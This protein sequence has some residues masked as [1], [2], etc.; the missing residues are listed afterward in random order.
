MQFGRNRQGKTIFA[1]T[2]EYLLKWNLTGNTFIGYELSKRK[3]S[4]SINN[5]DYGLSVVAAR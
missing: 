3:I 1:R 5:I 4:T 2:G